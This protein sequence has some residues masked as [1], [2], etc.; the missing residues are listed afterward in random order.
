MAEH[1]PTV[2]ELA[3]VGLATLDTH[4][5]KGGTA[6][7]RVSDEGHAQMGAALRKN[8]LE[9]RARNERKADQ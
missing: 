1:V 2:V 6:R 5:P 4:V 7:Y 8:G 9:A 3:H